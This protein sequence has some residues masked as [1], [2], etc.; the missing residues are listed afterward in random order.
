MALNKPE[1]SQQSREEMIAE[2]RRVMKAYLEAPVTTRHLAVQA[3]LRGYNLPKEA[4]SDVL[5][6]DL[7]AKNNRAKQ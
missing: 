2:T 3:A 5:P 4:F 1:S 6:P 7:A